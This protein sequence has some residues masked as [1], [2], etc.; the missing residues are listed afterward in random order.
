MK[1][2]IMLFGK[3]KV[4]MLIVL[5]AV[6][7]APNSSG[8]VTVRAR[9][10]KVEP[11][12]RVRILWTWGGRGQTAGDP[13]NGEFTEVPLSKMESPKPI[14]GD[15]FSLGT[16]DIDALLGGSGANDEYLVEKGK[17]SDYHWLLPG[18]WS[19]AVPLSSFRNNGLKYLTVGAR[20]CSL[21]DHRKTVNL[22]SVV[23]EFEIL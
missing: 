16:D 3:T 6:C 17:S 13:V 5:L 23:F 9:V 8:E 4:A 14:V 19:P 10:T 15:P 12:A 1:I 11:Q 18:V 7:L 22:K 20:G 2:L 21:A